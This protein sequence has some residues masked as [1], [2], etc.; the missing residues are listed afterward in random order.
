MA[1]SPNAAL[2]FMIRSRLEFPKIEIHR[3]MKMNGTVM[4]PSTNCRMVRPRE[5]RARNRPTNGAQAIHQAQKNSVQAFI[6]SV[7]RS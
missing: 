4:V 7:G 1:A 2:P 6:Q 5:M 3:T